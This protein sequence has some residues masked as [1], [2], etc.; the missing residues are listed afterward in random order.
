MKIIYSPRFEREALMVYE[1]ISKDKHKAVKEFLSK[2]K[3]HI[4]TLTDHPKKGRLTDD[5]YRE[6]IHKGYTIPYVIDE[7]NIVNCCSFFG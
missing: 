3:A 6:L 5:G 1:Y 7:E 2:V 4:E